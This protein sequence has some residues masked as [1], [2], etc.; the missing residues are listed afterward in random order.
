MIGTAKLSTMR[1]EFEKALGSDPIQELDR[2]IANAKR[3]GEGTEVMRGLRLFLQRVRKDVRRK[4]RASA[5]K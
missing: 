3:D 1:K 2:H 5:K 4:R